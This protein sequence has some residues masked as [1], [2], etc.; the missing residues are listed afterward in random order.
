MMPNRQIPIYAED[1]TT[2]LGHAS[3]RLTSVG[4]A[5]KVNCSFARFGFMDDPSGRK[6][7]GSNA[8]LR[9]S[10]WIAVK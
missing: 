2:L 7:P 9:V 1:R 3:Q 5:R 4:V 8:A 6:Q 10:C